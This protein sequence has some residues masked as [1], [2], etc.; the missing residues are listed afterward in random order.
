M[1]TAF[2]SRALISAVSEPYG[3]AGAPRRVAVLRN[4]RGELSIRRGLP[5]RRAVA[6]LSLVGVALGAFLFGAEGVRAQ[7]AQGRLGG[8]LELTNVEF[9]EGTN[10]F[11]P[12]QTVTVSGVIPWVPACPSMF[13]NLPN[14]NGRG[15]GRFD[16]FPV[17]DFYVVKD[18]GQPLAPGKKLEDVSGTP[19]R[20]IGLSD[21]SFVEEPVAITQP[22]GKLGA[23]KYRIVMN[24]C[25]TG[26]YDPLGGDIVLGDPA[27]VGFIVQLPGGLVPIDYNPLKTNAT[28]YAEALG[29]NKVTLPVGGEVTI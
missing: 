24:Q 7:A 14:I 16:F 21:G 17:A 28:Q 8:Y 11:G 27:N 20:V 18:D 9:G 22:T 19:N 3:L 6:I 26:Y 29:G 1:A 5:L 12:G 4:P 23:G 2:S 10:V 13:F 25:L 15:E